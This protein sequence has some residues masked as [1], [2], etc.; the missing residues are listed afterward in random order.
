M[1]FFAALLALAIKWE[2]NGLHCVLIRETV[3][4]ERADEC[5]LFTRLFMLGSRAHPDPKMLEANL[6]DAQ[7]AQY[8]QNWSVSLT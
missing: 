7:A 1:T 4:E 5:S 6:R 3:P 8:F 2:A